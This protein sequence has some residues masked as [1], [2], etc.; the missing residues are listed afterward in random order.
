MPGCVQLPLAGV[1]I[2]TGEDA[3]AGVSGCWRSVRP[4]KELKDVLRLYSVAVTTL[5]GLS[6]VPME[7]ERKWPEGF[8]AALLAHLWWRGVA[9]GSAER[10]VK[11]A[12]PACCVSVEQKPPQTSCQRHSPE[13]PRGKQQ[14]LSLLLDG[15]LRTQL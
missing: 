10:L 7:T 3:K 8:P 2:P 1:G 12:G 11:V 14:L 4:S 9:R 13:P 6:G 5:L 15:H